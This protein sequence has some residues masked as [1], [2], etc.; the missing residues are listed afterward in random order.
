LI[1]S[2]LIQGNLSTQFL[3]QH[4]E[5]YHFT[6]STNED[7][8]ELAIDNKAKNGSLVI[9]DDQ[10]KGKGRG[11]NYWFSCPGQNLTF[12]FLLKP[13][14]SLK[15][16]GL[17]S[18]LVGI[19]ICDGIKYFN[20]LNCTLKWP[21]DIF[22][23]NKKLGGILIES[24]EINKKKYLCV[25]I[26]ININSHLSQFPDNIQKSS[27][28][29]ISKTKQPIQRETILASILNNIESE[30]LKFEN[31]VEKWL[32]YCNHINADISFNYGNESIFGKFIGI[33][34]NG[35]AKLKIND[36]IQIFPGGELIL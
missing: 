31:I 27:I 13:K 21:N 28:S 12:S 14:L 36:E 6:N 32:Q 15:K 17:I 26:G 34:S 2:N 4:I 18:L 7:L 3:G 16:M 20:N 29:L 10:R 5:Y 8:W 25:G 35:Y 24:K 19:G 1:F 11:N 30:Y 9:T 23:D 22:L 33:N